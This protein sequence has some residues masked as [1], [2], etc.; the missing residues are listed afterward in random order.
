MK[1]IIAIAALA[2][3]VAADPFGCRGCNCGEVH[4][5]KEQ[6]KCQWAA[7]SHGS[8]LVDKHQGYEAA[9]TAIHDIY[10]LQG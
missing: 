10:G 3:A 9:K 1:Y 2:T 8:P 6:V 5:E 4:C 7:I